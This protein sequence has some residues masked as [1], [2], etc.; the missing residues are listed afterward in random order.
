MATTE[1]LPGRWVVAAL[2]GAF[3]L[4]YAATIDE[5]RLLASLQKAHPGTHFTEVTHSPVP[6]LYEVWMNGNVAYV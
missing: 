1:F 2:A 5:S 4:A 3:P 6:G